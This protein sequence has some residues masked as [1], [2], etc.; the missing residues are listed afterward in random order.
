M[1]RK[2]KMGWKVNYEKVSYGLSNGNSNRRWT[3]VGIYRKINV[4]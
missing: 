1:K 2:E 3:K 4:Y